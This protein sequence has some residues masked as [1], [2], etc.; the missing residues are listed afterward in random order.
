MKDSFFDTSVVIHYAS[1][2]KQIQ[3]DLV[4]RCYDYIV[5]KNGKFLLGYYVESEIKS[6]IKKRRII[7]DEALRKIK[8]SS[9]EIGNSIISKDLKERDIMQELHKKD[10]LL[11]VSEIFAQDQ[12]L[13]ERKIDQFLKFWVD[14]IIVPINSIEQDI[15][16]ILNE[17][18][19][20]YADCRVLASAIQ[21]Q[22]G[23]EV[24]YFVAADKD[25]DEPGYAFIQED[26]R[27]KRYQFPELYNFL[28]KK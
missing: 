4:K 8:N 21:A 7:Y 19:K 6:R 26:S 25:F 1:Y 12:A 3:Q 27:M 13:F 28:Y 10:K 14:E 17:F 2:N 15:I 24:F 18:I 5:N 16:N 20:N 11:T 23:R 22:R 9:Y